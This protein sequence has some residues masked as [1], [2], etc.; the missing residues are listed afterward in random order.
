MPP[1][2]TLLTGP[3]GTGKTSRLLERYR[4]AV[5]TSPPGSVLWLA[6]T[7]RAA[8]GIQNR[9]LGHALTVCFSPGIS[10]FARFTA[11]ILGQSP[12]PMRP[13]NSPLKR[14]LLRQLLEDERRAARLEHFG[15]IATTAGLLDLVCE[16]IRQM[17]RLEI[18]PE[19]FAEA[20]RE[21]GVVRKD[22]ELLAIYQAYQDRLVAHNLYDAE[23]QFWSARDL[24]RRQSRRFELVVADGFTDFTRTE[25]DML[26]TLAE[27][28]AQMWIS[29]PLEEEPGREDLF[30]K[31]LATRAELRRRHP[32]L[33]EETLPR[34]GKPSWPALAHL[35]KTIFSNPRGM[36]PASTL[37]GWK[38]SLAAVKSA[39]SKRSGGG[40]SGC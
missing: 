7:S 19:Q 38:S 3:A 17:K 6:P 35:E 36:K 27:Q 18:W 14:Q 25:H 22:R 2:V 24:L 4:G 1:L 8:A 26:Q 30:Q 11:A 37:P 15:P 28:S 10:T 5:A 21:R 39:R 12:Q 20:C 9:L 16:F 31:S 23:G 34:A 40:S 13:L 32:G 33:R 29:L